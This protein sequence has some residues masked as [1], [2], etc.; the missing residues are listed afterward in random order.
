MIASAAPRVYDWVQEAHDNLIR[1][2]ISAHRGYEINTE[3]DAF[4]I[5]FTSI[6]AAVCFCMEVQY[7]MLD[8]EWPRQV[9]RLPECKEI[10]GQDGGLNLRGP[11]VRMAIHF[12]V[13][14]SVL[15]HVHTVTKHRIF[16]GPA[17]QVTR[18]LCEIAKGGQ[19]LMTHQAWNK[20]NHQMA[21]A[22]FPVVEQLGLY[23]L[24]SWTDPILIYQITRLLGRSMH[25]ASFGAGFDA[26]SLAGAIK[27]QDG[28]GLRI[29]PPPPPQSQKGNLTFVV[30]RLALESCSVSDRQ[31]K[32]S[33][34]QTD[35]PPGLHK[36]L[37][38]ILAS[39]AMQFQGYLYRFG[40]TQGQYFIVFESALNAVR[41]S[42]A[43]QALFLFSHWPVEFSEWY[44]SKKLGADGKPLF[45][46]PRIAMAIHESNDYST[47]PIASG[48]RL[49]LG[50]RTK[51]IDY[52]GPAEEIC[53]TLS[54]VSHGGQVIL[55][56]NAWAAVQDGLPGHPCIISLGT[57]AFED[58]YISQPMMIMEVMPQPLAKR[59]FP[60]PQ[61]TTRIEPSY[62][63]APS[64]N[65][66]L[67]IVHFRVDKPSVVQSAEKTSS[68]L[69]DEDIVS[70][71]TSYNLAIAQAVKVAR[72]L[73]KT[74]NGYECKEPE[75]GKL[76]IA[77]HT[78]SAAITWAAAV[79][80]EL[81]H[82]K[83][84]VEILKWDEC[85]EIRDND[86]E[87]YND[88]MSTGTT[89][90]SIENDNTIT[91]AVGSPNN[92]DATILWRGLAARI[93][94]AAGN[95]AYKAPLNTGRADF[96]GMVPNLAARLVSIAQPGQI[97]VDGA[98]IRSIRGIKWRD[99]TIYL[100]GTKSFPEDIVISPLGQVA[101]KG[102]E[103]LRNIYQCLPASLQARLFAENQA[104]VR[105][106]S[107]TKRMLS[108]IKRSGNIQSNTDVWGVE[109]NVLDSKLAECP[110]AEKQGTDT[111][112]PKIF[113]SISRSGSV[114]PAN[115]VDR[116]SNFMRFSVLS[117]SLSRN[118]D[119]FDG[120]TNNSM[121]ANSIF[122]YRSP[123]STANAQYSMIPSQTRSS[124]TS[125]F[126][127]KDITATNSHQ[128][129]VLDGTGQEVLSSNMP[130]KGSENLASSQ[131]SGYDDGDNINGSLQT[132]FNMLID[133]PKNTD[134]F[135]MGNS[136]P[137]S[138]SQSLSLYSQGADVDGLLTRSE[139]IPMPSRIH[140]NSNTTE[141]ETIKQKNM[142]IL[143]SS[144]TPVEVLDKTNRNET[145]REMKYDD[146][147]VQY[148]VSSRK[149]NEVH[150]GASSGKKVIPETSTY[151]SAVS[152]SGGVNVARQ[153]A[154]LFVERRRR[155]TPSSGVKRPSSNV[156]DRIGNSSSSRNSTTD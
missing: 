152:I 95:G 82:T 79:Q 7:Q 129:Y 39:S 90:L 15:S 41:F 45:R 62:H 141:A 131:H 26:R 153:L 17:F 24:Q 28:A 99:D 50:S 101:I 31:K 47:R 126:D 75:S 51:L 121:A 150:L 130:F 70:I 3:G 124:V 122:P 9:L 120:T 72:H 1:D 133:A 132:P 100:S 115:I 56:E 49:I 140:A 143:S 137:S 92:F 48:N 148:E 37:L 108:S 27:I 13:E 8:V 67:A 102:F 23:K 35:V 134:L 58:P 78:L 80:V 127:E 142:K 59:K 29:V 64:G 112:V 156:E 154:Q 18:N 110:R 76:T 86:E 34:S 20:L 145:S 89:F 91:A 81:L 136:S 61:R 16:T 147:E 33:C 96:Y 60:P 44:G 98:M 77:F 83:W 38:E 19:V 88:I 40:E 12:A 68:G 5:A 97:L 55:S 57:L 114:S 149:K 107:M 118:S 4:H 139:P 73:L 111:I 2:A 43:A 123:S 106:I 144:S 25:R 128:S 87:E 52:V 53:R 116:K 63:D 104:I 10:K 65:E 109:G 94:I 151:K 84:P 54:L 46:G 30:C 66:E 11:R 146:L 42:H 71:I 155:Q 21:L 32:K 69:S 36:R 6:G 125:S 117:R 14:G 113:A 119:V 103:E 138:A 105:P 74:H 93:G 135:E 85:K 22:S